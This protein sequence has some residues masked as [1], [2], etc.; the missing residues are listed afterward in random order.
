MNEEPK[1]LAE[2]QGWTYSARV[3]GAYDRLKEHME[4]LRKFESEVFEEEAALSQERR[5]DIPDNFGEVA[6]EF[7]EQSITEGAELS[8]Q[9]ASE[10]A[11]ASFEGV[12][13]ILG[14]IFGEG[15]VEAALERV[16]KEQ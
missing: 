15:A 14:P 8:L 11:K 16:R 7:M 9:G 2:I 1:S 3:E 4:W 12:I 5:R 6:R 13:S 10:M